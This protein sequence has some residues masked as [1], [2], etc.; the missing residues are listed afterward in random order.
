MATRV[1]SDFAALGFAPGSLVMPPGWALH[2]DTWY[3]VHDELVIALFAH[4][5]H[6]RRA[7]VAISEE[8][9]ASPAWCSD[10]LG[11]METLPPEDQ[12]LR[13]LVGTLFS[14]SEFPDRLDRIGAGN[15]QFKKLVL[16]LDTSR[17]LFL[18]GDRANVIKFRDKVSAIIPECIQQGDVLFEQE[19]YTEAVEHFKIAALVYLTSGKLLRLACG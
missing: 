1:E 14:L 12:C 6:M 13:K 11:M 17:K 19:R 3:Y 15:R 16:T 4:P 2:E 7:T 9:E 5:G 10:A 18:A 8:T